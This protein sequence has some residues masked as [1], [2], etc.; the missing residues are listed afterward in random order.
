MSELK[1]EGDTLIFEGMA[2]GR[3]ALDTVSPSTMGR[4]TD[5][6]DG[7]DISAYGELKGTPVLENVLSRATT[8]AKA[9]MILISELEAIIQEL[10]E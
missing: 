8:K 5:A 2:I 1:L 3:L 10:E 4:I 9:G 7:I 6:L